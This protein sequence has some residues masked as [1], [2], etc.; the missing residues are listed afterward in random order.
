MKIIIVDDDPFVCMSLQT[1][2]SVQDDIEV[3]ATGASGDD[4]IRL[5]RDCAPD[6]L[7]MDIQM[8]PLSGLAAGEQILQEDPSARILFLTTFSDSEYIAQA[9]HMGARGYLIKQDIEGIAPALRAVMSG[10]SVFGGQIVQRLQSMAPEAPQFSPEALGLS[11]RE[12][13]IL[14]LVADGLS[15]REIAQQL[16]LSEGTVRNYIST[17]LDKLQLRDRTQLAVYYYKNGGKSI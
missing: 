5:C 11:E 1:I 7:L 12:A 8:Q 15:N 16:Y 13:E 3:L 2:L 14:Q 9:L 10:Q 6:I 4:A 17:L